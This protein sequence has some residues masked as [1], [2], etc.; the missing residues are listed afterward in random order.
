MGFVYR[1]DCPNGQY[2]IGS[3]KGTVQKR[4]GQHKYASRQHPEWKVYKHIQEN[5]GWSTITIRVLLE[6]DNYKQV[7]DEMIQNSLADPLCLNS[8]RAFLT[9]EEA[10][11]ANIQRCKAYYETNRETVRTQKKAYNETNREANIQRCKVYRE[12]NREA[13]LA[14][15]V[16][17]KEANKLKKTA[18]S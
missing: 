16:L 8:I 9:E 6:C 11:E 10:R 1:L 3:T 2:Y 12:T 17:A 4:L 15:R 7:E 5:E 18:V 14:K 13:I